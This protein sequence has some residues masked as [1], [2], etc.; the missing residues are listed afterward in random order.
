MKISQKTYEQTVDKLAQYLAGR[1][2]RFT[3]ERQWLLEK[4]CSLPQP[5]NPEQLRAACQ[6]QR[7]SRAT[8]YNTI[9]VLCAAQ[10]LHPLKRVKGMQSTEYELVVRPST[11]MQIICKH[12]GRV[13][14]FRDLSVA[15]QVKRRKFPNFEVQHFSLF[16]Y[17]ECKACRQRNTIRRKK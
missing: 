3:V 1:H 14:D 15:E 13:Q 11:R 17:G 2:M 16:V 5:F 6:E 4:I 8:V 12:C 9:E 7:I 10:I